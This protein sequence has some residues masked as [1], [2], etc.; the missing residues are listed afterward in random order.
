[1][2]PKFTSLTDMIGFLRALPK[3]ANYT[4]M[5]R[6]DFN[7]EAPDDA[8]AFQKE[9]LWKYL[10]QGQY[11]NKSGDD[12]M[13]YAVAGVNKIQK[14]Y[15]VDLRDK[16]VD[17]RIVKPAKVK[18]VKTGVKR[19]KYAPQA[20]GT[21]QFV[22]HRKIYHGWKGGKIVAVK[23]DA[24]KVRDILKSMGVVTFTEVTFNQ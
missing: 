10:V 7:I 19:T 8:P 14:E 1:M 2:I 17:N 3:D 9:Y 6:S 4:N 21:V 13:Q 20:D 12:L 16:P 5:L 11:H 23:S 22:A 18:V 15:Y 24:N